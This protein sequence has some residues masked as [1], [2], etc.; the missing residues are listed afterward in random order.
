[1]DK[2][3]KQVN[4]GMQQEE[5][6]QE[7]SLMEQLVSNSQKQLMYTRIIA[8]FVAIVS[9]VVIVSLVILVPEVHD[10]IQNADTL[11]AEVQDKMDTID[12]TLA[13]V[14]SMSNSI[15]GVSDNLDTFIQENSETLQGVVRNMEA[16]DFEGL[17]KAIKDLG[18]VVKPLAD[19]FNRF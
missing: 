6:K 19:F 1:M 17:N 8:V 9:M 18:D 4:D 3:R 14:K 16:I 7:L 13:G 11:L 10:L 12:E 5:T 2:R 15:S